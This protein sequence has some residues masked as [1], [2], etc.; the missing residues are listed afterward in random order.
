MLGALV[1]ELLLETNM[2]RPQHSEAR[3]GS[4]RTFG[5]A[6]LIMLQAVTPVFA[7]IEL[8]GSWGARN[9]SD[10]LSNNPG[11]RWLPLDFM[12]LPLNATGLWR[13]L[14]YSPS[15]ISMPERICSFYPPIYMLMGPFGLKIWNETEPRNGT[16]IAWHINGWEDRGPTTIWMDGRAHPS[17]NAPHGMSG[18]TTGQWVDDVLT[19]YTTHMKAGQVRKSGA[20]NS[21]QVTMTTRYFRHGDILTVTARID[22]PEYLAEPYYLTRTFQLDVLPAIRTVGP[23]CIQGDEGVAEEVVP[24]YLPG[25]NPFLD[26]IMKKYGI[27]PEASLGGAET[28]YPDIRK[29][30]KDKYKAPEQCTYACGGPG[31]FPLRLQ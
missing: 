27:P 8:S 16:T 23:P 30:I 6:C 18:F 31:G 5:V 22:D 25:K 14:I 2:D 9:Y 21:D 17:E 19:T 26:E 1:A 3:S 13:G 29:K 20:P 11:P 15:T 12:G 28:M 4:I 24:H 10:A 7:Q